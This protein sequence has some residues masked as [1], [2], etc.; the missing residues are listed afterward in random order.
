[1]LKT[2][3]GTRFGHYEFVVMSFG[4]TNTPTEFMELMNWVFKKCLD[5]LVIVFIDD[6][7]VCSK[8]MNT[9]NTFE[10]S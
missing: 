10:E 9:R 2:T 6:I 7:L 8:M 3:S 1:M 5:T 4:L